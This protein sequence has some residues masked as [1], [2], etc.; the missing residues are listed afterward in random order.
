MKC[1]LFRAK[2]K[3]HYCGEK[4]NCS[5]DTQLKTT[6]NWIISKKESK[7]RAKRKVAY[8]IRFK[9]SYCYDLIGFTGEQQKKIAMI[10]L[11]W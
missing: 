8:E 4:A 10:L 1:F 2:W 9:K 7:L 11:I 5:N 6:F 3:R